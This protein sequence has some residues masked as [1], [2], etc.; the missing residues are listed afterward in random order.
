M[1]D[2]KTDAQPTTG[3]LFTRDFIL[4]FLTAFFSAAALHSLT[5][6]LPIYLTRLGSNEREVGILVG[7]FAVASLVSRLFVGGALQRYQAKRVMM[8]GTFLSV[9][10]FVAAIIFRPF[11][12]FL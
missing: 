7:T 6:T 10:S 2:V 4:G 11:W 1:D 8:F 3:S 5:P 12:P 9:I